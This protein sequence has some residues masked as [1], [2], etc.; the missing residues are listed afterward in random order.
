MRALSVPALGNSALNE[1]KTM[2]VESFEVYS[3]LPAATQEEFYWRAIRL[4]YYRLAWDLADH[5]NHDLIDV[6]WWL[7]LANELE[8]RHGDK[9]PISL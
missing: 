1:E 2:K 7:N 3:K 4:G 5:A 8:A 6:D 9:M